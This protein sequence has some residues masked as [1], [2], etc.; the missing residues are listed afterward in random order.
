MKNEGL[1]S[2]IARRNRMLPG[3]TALVYEGKETTYG[4]LH[5]RVTRLSHAL[6]GLGI[7]RGDRVAYLGPNHPAFL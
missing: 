2:W 5:V 3:A 1:G 6:R 4:E 7:N